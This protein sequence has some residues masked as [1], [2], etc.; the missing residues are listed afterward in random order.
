MKTLKSKQ[1]SPGW[2]TK[3]YADLVEFVNTNNIKQEE[4]IAIT[5]HMD[6]F[7]IFYYSEDV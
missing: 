3:S 2:S 7:T 4:I 6:V 5:E 1:F